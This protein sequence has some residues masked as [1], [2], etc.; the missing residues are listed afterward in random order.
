MQF[1]KWYDID[2]KKPRQ[3]VPDIG[4][5]TFEGD[6]NSV[7][8][9]VNVFSDKTP[10]DV[11]GTI[12][13]YCILPNGVA[14][15]PWDGAKDGNRAWIDVPDDALIMNGRITLSIR[16][17]DADETT[18]LFQASATVRRV[19]SERHYDPE[20]E[21]GDVT[22]LIEEAERVSGVAAQAAQ[23]AQDA[24]A[25]ASDIVS[26]ATQTGQT[27][28]Q[29]ATARTNIEAASEQDVSDLRDAV[30]YLHDANNKAIPAVLENTDTNY[31]AW[32]PQ[33]ITYFSN[34]IIP[35]GSFIASV[36]LRANSLGTIVLI[37]NDN[38]VVYTKETNTYNYNDV[39]NHKIGYW[40]EED[41]R[42]GFAGFKIRY[43]ALNAT[44][45]T[46]L[47]TDGVYESSNAAPV[48]GDVLTITKT[49]STT[50]FR[51]LA[52]WHYIEYRKH[53]TNNIEKGWLPKGLQVYPN[54]LRYTD[55]DSDIGFIG[56]WYT[57][58]V[59][60][61]ECHVT[62]NCGSEFY[63]KTSG[64]TTITIEWQAM[65]QT[66]AYYVYIIDGNAPVRA[67]ITSNTIVLP[68][69]GV[70]YIRIVTDGITEEI[71][72]WE[73]GTGFAFSDVTVNQGS[74][75]GVMPT[76]PQ[77]MF[78]GDSITE[79]IRALGIDNTDM[80]NTNSATGAFPWYCCKKLNAIPF[81]IGYGATGINKTGSF[82]TAINALE[83]LYNG[84]PVDKYYP[85]AI[86][87]NYGA[88]D[89]GNTDFNNGYIAY[90]NA[91]HLMYP[92]VKVYI[93][94]PF[95][96]HLA[97][98]ITTVASGFDWAELIETANWD[99]ITYADG[100][101]PL[102][103]GAEVAGNYLADALIADIYD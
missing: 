78:F 67:S 17:F 56:R 8:I 70:H 77:I 87:I 51:F 9:G 52:Q 34:R 98:R 44:D 58:M 54:M 41:V 83:Y 47:A 35:K 32:T 61:H 23:D 72:K 5:P 27:D 95:N 97:S 46:V 24:L 81:R 102:A 99:G 85:D 20:D 21:I 39:L 84:T 33:T 2:L 1:E 29:K 10:S 38:K 66:N 76:N 26:Y 65:T 88:N 37:N 18:V 22:D 90:L 101:H 96:Q 48:V 62:N 13:G 71:G 7:R 82:N 93:M 68:D 53:G 19:D 49:T 59:N 73:N 55:I 86:V 94:I 45:D 69:S 31:N 36:D 28:A 80:G 60:G 42:I 43:K 25:Q 92:G 79:G 75:S 6:N 3:F 12:K 30:N 63:F 103:A 40:A 14:L 74:V 4:F 89:D 16:C 64:A 57:Q 91:M 15:M 100:I 11:T 50:L